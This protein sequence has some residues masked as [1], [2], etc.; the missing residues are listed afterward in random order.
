MSISIQLP[1]DVEARL[2]NLVAL[3][4]RSKAFYVTEAVMEHL[5]DIEGLYLIKQECESLSNDSYEPP[6]IEFKK[7]PSLLSTG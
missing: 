2:Q 1:Y 4:G 3:T 7:P 5:E 6:I